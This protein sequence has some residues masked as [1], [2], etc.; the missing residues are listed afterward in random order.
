M[1]EREFNSLARESDPDPKPTAGSSTS[2]ELSNASQVRE[3]CVTD[4]AALLRY[5][6]K[7]NKYHTEIASK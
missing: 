2:A 6:G 7:T 4:T 1:R 3:Q 5:S